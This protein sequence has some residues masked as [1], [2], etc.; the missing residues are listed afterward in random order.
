MKVNTALSFVLAGIALWLGKDETTS[1]QQRWVARVCATLVTLLGLL[2][3]GEYIF[4]Q[5]LGIDQL[6]FKDTETLEAAHPG[7]M[8]F[9]TAINF[10]LLGIALFV[11]SIQAWNE[12][13]LSQSLALMAGAIAL[14]AL[15]GYLYGVESLH[16]VG[17]SSSMALHA[18]VNFVLL[19]IGICCARPQRGFMKLVTS[20]AV[21]G[22]MVRRL[23]PFV[24]GMPV[25]LGWLRLWGQRLGF[26]DTTFGLALMVILTTALLSII[27]WRNAIWLRLADRERRQVEEQLHYQARLLRHVNDAVIATDEQLRISAWNRGAEKMYGWEA[28]EVIGRDAAEILRS[29]LSNEERAEAIEQLKDS[30]TA[31]SERLH[32]RKDGKPIFVE[33]NTIII[34]DEQGRTT[35]FVSVNRDITERKQAEAAVSASQKRFQSLIEHAPDGIALLGINGKL[36]QVTLSTEKIL[37]YTLEEAVDQDPA[38]LTHPD[39]LPN[40]LGLLGDLIQNPGKVITTEYR[41][42]HKDGSWRWLESTISNLIAEPSVQA[43]VFNYRDITEHK[44]SQKEVLRLNEELE[45]RVIE[46]TQQLEMANRE[47]DN[48]RTEIQNILDSMSTLNAKVALDGTLLFVNKIATQASGLSADELMKTNFLE[49]QW[50]AFDAEV[51]QRVKEAFAQACTGSAINY[52]EKIFVFGRILTINF[53]LT[54]MLGEDGRVEYILAE[55]RDITRRIRAEEEIRRLNQDLEQRAA[56]LEMVNKELESFSY[57]VSHDLRVPLRGIDG[58]SKAL[59]EDYYEILTE[60]GQ[61]YLRRIRAATQRMAELI[62]DLLSLARVTRIP[63]ERRPVNLTALAEKVL[64]ELQS[65][66]TDRRVTFTIAKDLIVEG[67]RQLLQIALENLISNAWK[68][69]SRKEDALIEV[70][71]QND[72]EEQVYFIRDNGAGFDMTYKNKLFGAFQRLHSSTEYPGTGIGLATVQRIIHRHGG[73]IW[74][75]SAVGKGT[76]FYFTISDGKSQ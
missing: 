53:S 67:D 63:L 42:K 5:N 6:I 10:V 43:I 52:E 51:Q 54:P 48:S 34:T 9:T 29:E 30:M 32:H 71:M 12:E 57:S 27:I 20:N 2:T 3:L 62:D 74:A 72:A 75:E 49:G 73:R 28:A 11:I 65:Q 59:W 1:H 61:D 56:E 60:D 13:R 16:Q 36:Q 25:I 45:Q 40:L 70:G 39:D 35:G 23:L 18:A 76:T 64:A 4:G 24:V 55:G 14:L 50:W 33:A 68:F 22:K 21:E 15:I 41:F 19:S 37:G 17:S 26:Y 38:M 69:T 47:L 7:R 66:Q 58:F 46:R 31:R 8:S 44:K